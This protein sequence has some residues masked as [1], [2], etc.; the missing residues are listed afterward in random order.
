MYSWLLLVR[1]HIIFVYRRGEKIVCSSATINP[2]PSL[3]LYE[4]LP[5]NFKFSSS[6][7]AGV[8]WPENSPPS[9]RWSESQ[10]DFRFTPEGKDHQFLSSLV[11]F[12]GAFTRFRI[13][14]ALDF[15]LS[16]ILYISYDF[17]VKWVFF[18]INFGRHFYWFCGLNSFGGFFINT[19]FS[20]PFVRTLKLSLSLYVCVC[21]CVCVCMYI[22]VCKGA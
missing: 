12:Y 13:S 10:L 21:V 5:L 9:D 7:A 1:I 3:S 15:A 14:G 2:I 8:A 22:G 4:P 18:L 6:L 11:L 17:G 16:L 20:L 19:L